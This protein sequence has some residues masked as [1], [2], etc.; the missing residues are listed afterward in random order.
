MILSTYFVNKTHGRAQRTDSLM[1]FRQFLSLLF[2]FLFF[3]LAF[4]LLFAVLFL[5]LFLLFFAFYLLDAI[6][7]GAEDL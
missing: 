5:A 6:D 4:S 2:F 1:I 7:D 3:L